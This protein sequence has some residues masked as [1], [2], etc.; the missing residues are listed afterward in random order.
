MVTVYNLVNK[1]DPE[2]NRSFKH[3]Q[4]PGQCLSF[5]NIEEQAHFIRSHVSLDFISS[6]YISKRLAVSSES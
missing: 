1:S 5:K 4:F 6:G 3:V 2:L